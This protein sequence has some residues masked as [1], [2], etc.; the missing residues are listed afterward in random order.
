MPTTTTKKKT[1]PKKPA[2]RKPATPGKEKVMLELLRRI[3]WKLL[4]EQKTWLLEQ[5][6]LG[7][8]AA[9]GLTN[10]L[11]VIQDGAVGLL[12]V[13]ESEVFGDPTP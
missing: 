3:D 12:G 1:T 2:T 8:K 13:P 5:A 4:R 11:D 9:E 7:S 10:M 6:V